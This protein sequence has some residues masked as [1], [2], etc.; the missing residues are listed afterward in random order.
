MVWP[1]HFTESDP[2][3]VSCWPVV[4][5][6]RQVNTEGPY[7]SWDSGI[8]NKTLISKVSRTI[9]NTVR[10]CRLQVSET[11]QKKT[12]RNTLGQGDQPR[13]S[14]S[15]GIT[16]HATNMFYKSKAVPCRKHCW[17][18]CA[19]KIGGLEIP[20]KDCYDVRSKQIQSK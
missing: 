4:D 7:G 2:C 6:K 11:W 15:P 20:Q 12:Q 5:E 16:V 9:W 3:W 14:K 1:N 13:Q 19:K 8:T 10:T 17:E 18:H